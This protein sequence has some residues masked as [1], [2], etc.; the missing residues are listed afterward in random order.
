MRTARCSIDVHGLVQGVGFRP[1][2]HGLA[3]RFALGGFVRNAA[4]GV[5][6]EVEGEPSAIAHFLDELRDSP[7]TAANVARVESHAETPRGELDFRIV[8]STLRQPAAAHVA[9]DRATCAEC[10]RELFDAENRRFLHPF[11]T[12]T[13]CGPRATIIEQMP[14]DRPRTTMAGFA[15]CDGCRQEYESVADRR[16]HAQPIACP[17]CGPELRIVG[18]RA[19]PNAL[20]V[21]VFAREISAGRIGALKGIGGFHLV[22]DAA[23]DGAVAEL[24]RRKRREAK[25]FAVM[26]RDLDA[27]RRLAH[28]GMCAERLLSSAASP[29]VLVER[30]E[31]AV[32]S[33]EVA[34]GV[35]TVG[36]SLPYTPVHLLLFRELG[37]R[38][39]VV[40]SGNRSDEPIAHDDAEATEML[41]DVAD[42]FLTHDRDIHWPCDD[43]VVRVVAEKALPIRRARGYAP[44]PVGLRF[45]VAQPTL[46]LGGHQKAVFALGIGA[47]AFL[48]T[49]HGD[50]DGMRAF[51][52]WATGAA[53]LER[54]LGSQA[55]RLVHDL[56]PDYASTRHALER[57]A[58]GIE[59]V[60][61]QHHHAH[62]ASCMVDNELDGDVIGVCFDGTG[63]GTD[64]KL[65]GGEFLVGGYRGFVRAG[66]L[67][68]VRLPGG[69]RAAREP[70]RVALSHLR[71][72]GL[73][74]GDVGLDRRIERG[75]LAS[76]D[77][78]LSS[79]A[80]PP[81]TSM[82]RLFDAIASIAGVVD[83]AH[84]DAEAGMRLEALAAR[85]ADRKTYSANVD[86]RDALIVR[87]AD[88]VHSAAKDVGDGASAETIA[89]RFH[90]AVVDL[91]EDV[92]TRLRARFELDRVV[93]SG[94][95]FANAVLVREIPERLGARG[96]AVF[97]HHRVPPNDG[98][99]CLGQLAIAA[100]TP[101]RTTASI[102]RLN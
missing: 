36:L 29:I 74:A 23:N 56:H 63:L 84:H 92:C 89:R 52:S 12:C 83:R 30:R 47:L 97:T 31:D 9:A 42:V 8:A 101:T 3:R 38:P 65:W 71:N 6:I 46:A 100:H 88:I 18:V 27:A 32:L 34:P 26:V 28:I 4:S 102:A 44:L 60:G 69:D 99:L 51:T 43:S 48:G 49:H 59:L 50:L 40:T 39:L 82:G 54:L 57:A 61:V 81:T 17:Q 90:T 25:P 58:P 66:H 75:L 78:L 33:R 22:C 87:T 37:E 53:H 10:Q 85:S 80:C 98:G 96:F 79:S 7:P 5:H 16:F 68:E 76:V 24:R 94:G 73:G 62:L 67:S 15:M 93:L 64:G 13:T 41:A 11:I 2:V 1:F 55:R 95:V 14:Y 91:V 77:R 86:D 20:P 35:D 70:F 45:E 19:E 72:A 21:A